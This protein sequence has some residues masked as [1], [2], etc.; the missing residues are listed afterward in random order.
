MQSIT[1][2]FLKSL[3]PIQLYDEVR[4]GSMGGDGGYVVPLRAINRSDLLISLG[5]GFNF[6]FEKHFLSQ[7]KNKDV[8]LFESSINLRSALSQ[9]FTDSYRR[10]LG[11]RG[12]PLFRVKQLLDLIQVLMTRRLRYNKKEVRHIA[13]NKNQIAFGEIVSDISKPSRTTL[14]IDIEGA[15]YEILLNVTKLSEINCL[16]IEFHDLKRKRD[17]FLAILNKL[18]RH[19]VISHLHLNN[20]AQPCDGVPDVI[21]LTLINR[22]LLQNEELR[23]LKKVLPISLDRPCDPRIPDSEIRF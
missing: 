1:S 8:L 17:L 23:M 16:V 18:K 21:E 9:L 20:F 15:E 7:S 14:K 11:Q 5:Y 4:L 19:F 2:E 13:I 6:A 3:Q 10:L 22:Q 12:F